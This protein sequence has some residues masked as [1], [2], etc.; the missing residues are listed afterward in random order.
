MHLLWS[1][2]LVTDLGRPLGGDSVIWPR[3]GAAA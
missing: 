3:A 2:A 1:G